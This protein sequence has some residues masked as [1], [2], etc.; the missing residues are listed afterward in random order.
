MK[1]S[2]QVLCE[3]AWPQDRIHALSSKPDDRVVVG[4]GLMTDA[5]GCLVSS[6]KNTKK[7]PQQLTFLNENSAR[8]QVEKRIKGSCR[9]EHVGEKLEKQAG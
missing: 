7:N 9:S 6:L 4:D 2:S 8:F 5:S 3:G 1:A